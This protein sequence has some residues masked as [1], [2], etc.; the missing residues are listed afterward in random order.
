MRT[1]KV[2]AGRK[3]TYVEGPLSV[4]VGLEKVTHAVEDKSVV[5][6][7]ASEG[8]TELTV[9][10]HFV[11]LQGSQENA[12]TRLEKDGKNQ[13]DHRELCGR[14]VLV[15]VFVCVRGGVVEKQ[16]RGKGSDGHTSG[17]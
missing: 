10:H 11:S 2:S 8:S 13:E 5:V 6:L 1:I 9:G 14:P 17:Y 15:A 3:Q 16:K 7:V 12:R 4:E